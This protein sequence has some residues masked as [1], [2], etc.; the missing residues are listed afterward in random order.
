[1]IDSIFGLQ[2]LKISNVNDLD[3]I[4]YLIIP[5]V[6]AFDHAVKLLSEKDFFN[7]FVTLLIEVIF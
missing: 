3:N 6:G 1:M 2:S 5:G 7:L 4:S